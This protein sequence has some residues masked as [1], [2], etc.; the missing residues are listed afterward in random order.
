MKYAPHQIQW[1]Y[2]ILEAVKFQ[3]NPIE[4]LETERE[5]PGLLD[6][7]ALLI[8]L[9]SAAKPQEIEVDGTVYREF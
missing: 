4:I 2:Y 8:N 1:L 6:D 5:Y 3:W 9:L 7:L